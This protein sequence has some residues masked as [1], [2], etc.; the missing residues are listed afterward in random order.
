MTTLV[1]TISSVNSSKLSKWAGRIACL[2]VCVGGLLG[3]AWNREAG[4][5]SSVLCSATNL[6]GQTT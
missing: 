4:D 1:K 3:S 2:D 6:L 5:L